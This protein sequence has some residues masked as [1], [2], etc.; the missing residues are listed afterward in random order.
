MFASGSADRT[1]RI[2][3]M[4][5]QYLKTIYDEDQKEDEVGEDFFA[6]A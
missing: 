5:D 4:K 6:E 1:V 2:W 3:K